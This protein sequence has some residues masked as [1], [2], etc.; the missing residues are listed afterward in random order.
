MSTTPNLGML[1]PIPTITPGPTYASENNEAFDI[2]DGHDHTTGKGLPVPSNGININND[3]PYNGFNASDLRSTQFFNNP[4]P[5]SLPADI[6]AVYVSG[7]DLW[8]NNQLGQQVQITAGS[9]LNAGS[10]GGIGGDY[11]GSGALEFYTSAS[12]TFTFWSSTNV[13]AALDSGPITLRNI[14][15]G[16]NGITVNPPASIPVNYSITLPAD[17][18]AGS[19]SFL[20]MNTSNNILASVPTASAFVNTGNIVN[21]SVTQNKLAL[22][23]VGLNSDPGIG[24]IAISNP[25]TFSQTGNGNINVPG[26]TVTLT[27]SGRPV[28]I[29]LQ[30]SDA[31]LTS[32][33]L[34]NASGL[35]IEIARNPGPSIFLTFVEPI[36]TG[37]E[38]MPPSAIW[39]IDVNSIP[40]G[41]YT[42]Q[43]SSFG[44]NVSASY[45]YVN[46]VMIAYEL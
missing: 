22:K 25:I 8:Y 39:C 43:V 17:N 6:T 7:G 45:E 42:Y 16:S 29:G 19:L 15:L 30:A 40:A 13:P 10:I 9:S 31:N 28:F 4:S 46:V 24:G 3:L 44:G 14:S 33:I 2:I 37:T 5:L 32:T 20:T 35:T 12:K 21:Q 1:L 23:T 11:V 36:S 34:Y 27:T 26:L 18:T 41:T 38:F